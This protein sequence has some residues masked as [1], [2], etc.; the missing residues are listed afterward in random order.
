MMGTVRFDL[1]P[2]RAMLIYNTLIT[3]YL[4]YLGTAGHRKGVLL[5]PGFAVHALV[6]LLLAGRGGGTA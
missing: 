5:W 6:A 4:G 1:R 3:A 2:V